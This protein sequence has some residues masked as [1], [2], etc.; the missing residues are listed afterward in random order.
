MHTQGFGTMLPYI[1]VRNA[2]GYI[3]FLKEVIR[4]PALSP[5]WANFATEP[6]KVLETGYPEKGR[7]ILV[8]GRPN[9]PLE[10]RTFEGSRLRGKVLG[11]ELI[12]HYC[13]PT[14][15]WNWTCD[16]FGG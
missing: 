4:C 12:G 11:A 14:E 5:T 9:R 6:Q 2:S 1:F 15:F 8:S 3:E 16:H 7:Y 10:A 13:A